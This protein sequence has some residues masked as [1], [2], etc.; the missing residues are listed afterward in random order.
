M[1]LIEAAWIVGSGAATAIGSISLL[2]FT[3]P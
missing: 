3:K 2:F 1:E